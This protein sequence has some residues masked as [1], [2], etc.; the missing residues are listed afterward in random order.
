M[1]F[2]AGESGEIQIL[3]HKNVCN[4]LLA[5]ESWGKKLVEDLITW[6]NY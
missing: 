4:L 6:I 2:P 3:K 5:E 1:E